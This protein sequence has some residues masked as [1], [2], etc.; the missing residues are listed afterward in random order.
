MTPVAI[1]ALRM[2]DNALILS[3]RTAEWCGHAPALEEDIAVAN[4]GLDLLGQAQLWYAL[5]AE[6]EGETRTPDDLAFLRPERQFVNALLVEQPNADFAHALVRQYLF[7]AWH[8]PMLLGL[9][10]STHEGVR[11][12]AEKAVKEVRYHLDRSRDL[13]VRL[14]D[15]SEESHRRM[16]GALDALYPFSLDLLAADDLER[17]LA[18]DGVIQD[19]DETRRAF[20]AEL[21]RSLGEATLSLAPGRAPRT[22]GRKGIHT[23]H[24]GYLLAEMQHLHRSHPGA[25]W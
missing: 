13:L 12:I 11:A 25:R 14:G 23:E 4:V 22:G 7:D 10:A 19:P 6:G 24:M 20:E 17:G 2:G 3:Q 1:F 8:L 18:D 15:G 16:Q 9:T 21:T 5:V